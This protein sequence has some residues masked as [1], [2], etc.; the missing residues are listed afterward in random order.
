MRLSMIAV[1]LLLVWASPVLACEEYSPE[2]EG[3]FHERATSSWE[4][5][6]SRLGGT[7]RD[8]RPGPWLLGAG[9]AAVALVGVSFRAYSRA[10]GQVPRLEQEP[11]AP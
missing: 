8:D 3:W 4:A 9:S 5:A 10:A 6:W 1:C 11:S 7:S 2:R